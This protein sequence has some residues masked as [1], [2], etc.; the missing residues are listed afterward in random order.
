MSDAYLVLVTWPDGSEGLLFPRPGNVPINTTQEQ[1]LQ[2]YAIAVDH[3][4]EFIRERKE[5][6]NCKVR[7]VRFTRHEVVKEYPEPK[8]QPSRESVIADMYAC[9]RCRRQM[10]HTS[11]FGYI[12]EY[13]SG[14]ED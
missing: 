6:A 5:F 2:D 11:R 8:P 10:T 4:N 1:G 12:C 3:L 9:P 7:L 13:C 14:I